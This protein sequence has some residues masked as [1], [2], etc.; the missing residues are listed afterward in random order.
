VP[1]RRRLVA[2]L[3]ALLV[4]GLGVP[5]AG[6]QELPSPEDLPPV[7]ELPQAEDPPAEEPAPTE[8]APEPE[9]PAGSGQERPEA[10]EL[11]NTGSDARVV[12]LLGATVLLTGVGLRLRTAPEHF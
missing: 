5:A 4:A 7:S 1:A 11:P 3:V 10:G 6:A 12:A 9:A 8:P 2:P